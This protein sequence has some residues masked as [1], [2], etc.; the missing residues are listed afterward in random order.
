MEHIFRHI[1]YINRSFDGYRHLGDEKT[2]EE[3]IELHLGHL[4]FELI[5]GIVV[6]SGPV[7]IG[8]GIIVEDFFYLRLQ[9]HCKPVPVL[10]LGDM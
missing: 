5:F 10:H 6:E 3:V 2:G 1:S 7:T 4:D 9:Q 8:S